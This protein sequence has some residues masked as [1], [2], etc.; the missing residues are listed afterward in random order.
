MRVVSDPDYKCNNVCDHLNIFGSDL[1]DLTIKSYCNKSNTNDKIY[2]YTF[3][4]FIYDPEIKL[5]DHNTICP[6]YY[7]HI[8]HLD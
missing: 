7:Y 3:D 5:S 4:N 1:D 6:E 8:N 2:F